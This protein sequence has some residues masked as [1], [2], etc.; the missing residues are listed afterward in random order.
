ML[1]PLEVPLAK[2]IL[3]PMIIL[4]RPMVDPATTNLPT[5]YPNKFE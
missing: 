2:V 5:L 3:G 4:L 1:I